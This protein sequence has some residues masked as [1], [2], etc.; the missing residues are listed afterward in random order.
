MREDVFTFC[1]AGE[2]VF[3]GKIWMPDAVRPRLVVQVAHGMTEHIGRYKG[4]AE[5]VTAHGMALAG[6]DLRGHGQN[7]PKGECASFGEGGWE[8]SLQDM[9][10]CHQALRK[11][12]KDVPQVL[13]GFS[14][15]SFLLRDYLSMYNT[16]CA[17]AIIMGTGTQSSA[18][19][20]ALK[21]LVKG[22]I[23]KAGF[24]H[25]TPLVQKLSFETYNKQFAPNRSAFDWLISDAVEVA[26]YVQDPLC[27]TAI[28][29]GL[30]WQLLDAMQRTGH[31][32]NYNQW[33][34]HMPVMLL[35]GREDP[36]GDHGKG[37]E[38][39]AKQMEKAGMN[40]LSMFLM[41]RARHDVLHEVEN[42]TAD[43]T[44]SMIV[45]FLEHCAKIYE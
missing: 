6:Y 33:P 12:Y 26:Q 31:A 20:G 13:L 15:G 18:V 1:G 35:S 39:V 21:L 27:K 30:F 10:A 22:E 17:G 9:H 11:L 42:G 23:K 29:S 38:H 25:T 37:V 41:P 28:S 24:D 4:L 3:R 44:M 7:N 14:L 5:A 34:Q 16:S 43:K 36:V 45:A 8:A 40:D 19:L 32:S 2:M